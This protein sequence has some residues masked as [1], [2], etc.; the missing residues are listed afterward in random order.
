MNAFHRFFDKFYPAIRYLYEEIQGHRWFDQI[1]P[2]IWLG[3]AP[4]Y[5]RDYQFILDHGITG[6]INIRAEREDD[7]AFYDTHNITHIR[8]EVP[9]VT[10]PKEDVITDAVDWMKQ[11]I[12]DG[13]VVLVHC[14]KGRGRSATLV[15]AYLM[16]EEGMSF[17]EANKLMKHKRPLTKLEVKHRHR[18]KQWVSNHR[19]HQSHSP[20]TP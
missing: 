14:A 10:V 5:D 3:G 20:L 9:D 13:R 18:L 11:E 6:V 12:D 7:V 1:T 2:E 8:Y 16:R 15:A 17:D 4:T 19:P